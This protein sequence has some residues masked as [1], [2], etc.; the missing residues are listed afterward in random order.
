MWPMA[1]LSPCLCVTAVTMEAS[2]KS[3][4][5]PKLG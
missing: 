4:R 3:D 5:I 2:R 1:I